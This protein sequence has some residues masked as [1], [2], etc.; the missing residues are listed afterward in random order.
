MDVHMLVLL[1]ARERTEA[2]FTGLLGRSGFRVTR[3]VPTPSPAGLSVI[4]AT[5]ELA[6]AEKFENPRSSAA[7]GFQVR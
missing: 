7:Q 2:E 5:V 4:E 3:V 6:S 1:G